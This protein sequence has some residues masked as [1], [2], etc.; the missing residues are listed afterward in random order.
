M[1][2]A[3]EAIGKH[4]RPGNR[5]SAA[6]PRRPARTAARPAPR[7]RASPAHRTRRGGPRRA[8]ASLL[9]V[10]SGSTI[11]GTSSGGGA[12]K[13]TRRSARSP[14]QR[15]RRNS[16]RCRN[17]AGPLNRRGIVKRRGAVHRSGIPCLLCT[18]RRLGT[19][20]AF[21]E[22][23]VQTFTAAF[24]GPVSGLDRP[25]LP[26]RPRSLARLDRSRRFSTTQSSGQ[27][28]TNGISPSAPANRSLRITQAMPSA[29]STLR[30][31]AISRIDSAV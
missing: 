10:A 3:N 25:S 31:C 9:L 29:S 6:K 7:V 27:H 21:V 15:R 4:V 28:S 30:R 17:R 24:A 16:R 18:T 1:R 26:A 11:I 12:S 14:P 23:R 22:L 19:T 13:R 5:R 20:P 8:I 2:A